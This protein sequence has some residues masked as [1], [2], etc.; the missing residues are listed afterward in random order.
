MLNN[1]MFNEAF[2]VLCLE[3]KQDTG[4]LAPCKD[5]PCGSNYSNDYQNERV[6]AWKWWMKGR[7]RGLNYNQTNRI[8]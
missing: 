5:A 1:E 8:K 6:M 2:D 4:Y 3:F 7:E